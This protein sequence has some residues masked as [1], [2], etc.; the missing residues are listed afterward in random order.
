M[1]ATTM[2]YVLGMIS[3]HRRFYLDRVLLEQTLSH[4]MLCVTV[5]ENST[6]KSKYHKELLEIVTNNFY[7]IIYVSS[8]PLLWSFTRSIVGAGTKSHRVNRGRTKTILQ[9]R[10]LQ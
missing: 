8:K 1:V 9:K 7:S 10:N 4:V 3:N 2:N 6:L 5:K